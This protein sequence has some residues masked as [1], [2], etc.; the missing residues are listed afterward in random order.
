MG[1]CIKID[2]SKH[3]CTYNNSD[4]FQ[5][6]QHPL[7]SINTDLFW[8]NKHAYNK[9][10]HSTDADSQGRNNHDKYSADAGNTD[11]DY[12]STF[13]SDLSTVD[14]DSEKS[15]ILST[16]KIQTMAVTKLQVKLNDLINKMKQ[17]WECTMTFVVYSMTTYHLVNLIHMQS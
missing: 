1:Y 5:I 12:I 11:D 17:A 8:S 9:D 14:N 7:L 16:K 6:N 10:V 3:K 2:V 4:S 15:T 13:G